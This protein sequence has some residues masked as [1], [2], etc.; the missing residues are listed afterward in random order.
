MPRGAQE[1]L[2]KRHRASHD[3]AADEIGIGRF[4]IGGGGDAARQN[5]IAEP[6]RETL[7]LIFDALRHIHFR[8]IRDVTIGPCGM[9]SG[10]RAHVIKQAGLREQ[11]EGTFGDSALGHFVFRAGNL[12]QRPAQ[13]H[14]CCEPAFTR[15]PRD[16]L[17]QGVV[18]FECAG[19]EM[20]FAEPLEIGRGETG[21]GDRRQMA[22]R[23]IA[24]RE[25]IG[26]LAERSDAAR[27]VDGSAE[28]IET[29]GERSGN[30]LRAPFRNRPS[31]G[32][33]AGREHDSDGGGERRVKAEKRMGGQTREDSPGSRVIEAV[34]REVPGR[35][36]RHKTETREQER[37]AGHVNDWP[38]DV[39]GEAAPVFGQRLEQ[40]APASA[41]LTQVADGEVEVAIEQDCVAVFKGVR[42]IGGRVQPAKAESLEGQ[43]CKE[44]RAEGQR[45]NGRAEVVQI[46]GNRE[47]ECAGRASRLA[48]S[49]VDVHAEPGLR[50]DQG[51][52]EAVGS[53]ADDGSA[54]H[55]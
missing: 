13:V 52:G 49:F 47:R 2:A 54:I 41:V 43:G 12:F 11:D 45:M 37:V 19:A 27:G 35:L 24:Q 44:W 34:L 23:N 53:G 30:A 51:G 36:H 33:H 10:G 21:S 48:F 18:N 50:E 15:A 1:R 5:A 7:D 28:F 6:G 32:M 17:C 3:V 22:R 8:S 31:N 55:V 20:K 46:A 9:R 40:I 38:E 4:E 16:G 25:D 26:K 42:E 14:G 29:R 39:L